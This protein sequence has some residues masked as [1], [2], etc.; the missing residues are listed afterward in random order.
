MVAG[1]IVPNLTASLPLTARPWKRTDQRGK[2]MPN[3]RP[4]TLLA[5]VVLIDIVIIRNDVD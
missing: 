2:F 5:A 1:S 4:L 3:G